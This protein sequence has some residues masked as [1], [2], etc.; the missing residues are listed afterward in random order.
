MPKIY[1]IIV[2]NKFSVTIQE[3][4]AM[5]KIAR[6]LSL[7]HHSPLCKY[8]YF[9]LT[10]SYKNILLIRLILSCQIPARKR[11]TDFSITKALL[12]GSFCTNIEPNKKL[13]SYR[14]HFFYRIKMHNFVASRTTITY[15]N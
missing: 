9:N 4:L 11:S 3:F 7:V 13:E 5:S 14:Y 2:L 10:Y 12:A 15:T 6:I 1:R 8:K